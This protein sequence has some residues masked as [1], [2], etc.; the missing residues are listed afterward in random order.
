MLKDKVI[1]QHIAII[2]DGNGRW[3]KQQNKERF[4][5]HQQGAETLKKIA[6]YA[7]EIGVKYMTVY[8]FS[9]ENWGRPKEE[10][11]S[12]MSLLI[13]G[14]NEHLDELNKYQLVLKIIG[15]KKTLPQNVLQAVEKAEISTSSNK[16]MM[17]LIALN[18]SGRCEI[19]NAVRSIANEVKQNKIQTEQITEE[20]FA[21]YLYT[22]DIPDPDLLIRTSGEFR[23]SNFLLWQLSYSELYTTDTLWPDFDTD[24]LDKA[25]INFNS[26]QRRFGKT[27]E[28]LK[29]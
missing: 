1:P 28:Q 4:F 6:V 11:E 23:L 24:C 2:M 26:R 13:T 22:K 7:S 16:G 14:V 29:K 20:I 17:L 27:S 12:L 10:V 21:K 5:G 25:I 19:I 15:D 18:Y 8:A 3:A 9:K